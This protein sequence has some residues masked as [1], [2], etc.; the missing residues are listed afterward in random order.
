MPTSTE[1]LD[2]ILAAV[3]NLRQRPEPTLA[4][5]GNELMELDEQIWMVIEAIDEGQGA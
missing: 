2:S 5:Y 3:A 1:Y 4:D